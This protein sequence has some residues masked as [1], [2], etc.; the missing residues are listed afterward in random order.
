MALYAFDGTWNDSSAP[1]D[2]RDTNKDTNEYANWN[3]NG[4]A[5]KHANKHGKCGKGQ[6]RTANGCEPMKHIQKAHESAIDIIFK[7]KKKAA[8]IKGKKPPTK[9]QVILA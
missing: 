7:A 3:A 6:H 8:L 2:Q 5:N 9:E 4:D 1:E